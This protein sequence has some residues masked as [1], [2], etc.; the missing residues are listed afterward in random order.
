MGTG[1]PV[2][3]SPITLPASPAVDT[4]VPI[5]GPE[6]LR[7]HFSRSPTLTPRYCAL[8]ELRGLV[9]LACSLLLLQG[10]DT[11][12]ALTESLPNKWVSELQG[13][14][15]EAQRGEEAFRD[16]PVNCKAAGAASAPDPNALLIS[17]LVFQSSVGNR[18]DGTDSGADHLGSSPTS[19]FTRCSGPRQVPE[20]QFPVV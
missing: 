16:H 20:F 19:D 12:Q 6:L 11:E 4:S 5:S 13:P 15:S 3:C 1:S 17:P 10:L 2:A 14:Y 8:R 7:F 18:P 9:R